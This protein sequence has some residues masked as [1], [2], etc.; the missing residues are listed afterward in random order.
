MNE[1]RHL[2]VHLFFCTTKHISTACNATH[3]TTDDNNNS[4]ILVWATSNCLQQSVLKV[5]SDLLSPQLHVSLIYTYT[6][7]C[8][9][10]AEWLAC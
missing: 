5:L 6:S 8:G 3:D 4:N 1:K 7:W 2:T 9:S 10:V